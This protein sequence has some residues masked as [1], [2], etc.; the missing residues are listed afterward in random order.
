MNRAE[1]IK[2]VAAQNNLN[3]RQAYRSVIAVMDTLRLV[4]AQGDSVE[5]GGFGTFQPVTESDGTH[6]PT[7][8]GNRVLRKVITTAAV[9]NEEQEV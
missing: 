1:F 8:T 3:Q 9:M 7:F 6:I 2:A 5:I 4:L